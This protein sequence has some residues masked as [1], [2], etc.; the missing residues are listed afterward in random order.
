M[1]LKPL[2]QSPCE[3]QFQILDGDRIV[4]QVLTVTARRGRRWQVL[5][6]ADSFRLEDEATS[7]Y[8]A[9][10][11]RSRHLRAV[12]DNLKDRSETCL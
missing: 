9:T 12:L 2:R 6:I 3:A 5:T 4:G 10:R 11:V 8:D 1:I 7:R